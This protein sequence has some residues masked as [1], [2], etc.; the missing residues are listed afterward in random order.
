MTREEFF[1]K[2]RSKCASEIEFA[3]EII[4]ARGFLIDEISD[5]WI[6]SDNSH[7]D[8]GKYLDK[9]LRIH[10]IGRVVSDKIVIEN[11]DCSEFIL[12]GFSK[13]DHYRS[14]CESFCANRGWKYFKRREHG[15]KVP[16]CMLDPFIA[17]YIKAIS[18]CCVSTR[19][20]CDGDHP[21]RSTMVIDMQGSH[22]ALWHSLIAE[23]CLLGRF[24]IKWSGKHEH[25]STIRF[26]KNTKYLTYH[27]VNNA[28][29]LLYRNRK[30][31]RLIKQ[32]AL[33]DMSPKYLERHP[34]DEIGR[35]FAARASELFDHALANF[36]LL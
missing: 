29:E 11:T 25:Y 16:V 14:G 24:D 34:S 8:D 26:G 15:L 28:A 17:R 6:V 27:E 2:I 21:N 23:K 36:S 5:E 3:I 9:L 13:A 30:E 31:I 18:A 1:E 4:K 35:E 20:S 33:A 12:D 19:G 32:T 10:K 7:K 22:D